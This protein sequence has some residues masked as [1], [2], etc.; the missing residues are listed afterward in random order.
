MTVCV[1]VTLEVTVTTLVLV[2]DDAS[3]QLQAPETADGASVDAKPQ[4]GAGL[5]RLW[6]RCL[7]LTAPS[8][9]QENAYDLNSQGQ[10]I[11][12]NMKSSLNSLL[13]DLK[14]CERS[15]NTYVVYDVTVVE[16]VTGAAVTTVTP[17]FT[18]EVLRL[19][20]VVVLTVTTRGTT[21]VEVV[22]VVRV[23]VTLP[24]R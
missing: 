11:E 23:K 6:L 18:V 12:G 17:L 15:W 3:T 4:L 10:P 21:L 7:F 20:T 1:D 19:L 22:S 8:E 5:P 13:S 14:Q 2:V 9:G 16:A 24:C